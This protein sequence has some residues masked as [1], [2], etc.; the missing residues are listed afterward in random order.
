MTGNAPLPWDWNV[1]ITSATPSP[2]T[3]ADAPWWKHS[4]CY[5]VYVR[6]FADSDGDGVGDLTGIE[7]RL[8]YLAD[9]GVDSVWITPF[10]TSP[11]NDHGY[12]VA[13]YRDVDRLFGSLADF[14][15][16]LARAHEL[17]LRVI[18]DLVPNHTSLEHEW[19]Q[20]A[21]AAGPGHPTRDLYVFRD[22]RGPDGEDMR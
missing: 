6:S 9:L 1:Q 20:K 3:P 4:V 11:Q 8:P 7:Q 21:L 22:G 14:D 12:D 19:F 17:G 5:Q 15:S 13:D 18:V 16:M 2:E 10:Y